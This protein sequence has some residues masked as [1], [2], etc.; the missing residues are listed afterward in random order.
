MELQGTSA[1][2]DSRGGRQVILYTIAL[3]AGKPGEYA[4][5]PV[6]LRYLPYGSQQPLVARVQGPTLVVEERR[7]MGLPPWAAGAAAAAL[8][9]VLAGLAVLARRRS[10]PR[11][12]PP[13]EPAAELQEA[14]D[15]ARERRL[16]GD[17]A[18]FVSMLLPAMRAHAPSSAT[19]AVLESWEEKVRYGGFVPTPM[20]LD[21]VERGA[22]QAI[23]KLR[24][25]GGEA[26]PSPGDGPGNARKGK[27]P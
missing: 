22:R 27:R 16:S 12:E 4:L 24:S 2:S 11:P 5:D 7:V 17:P 14:L 20:D 15:R 19:L 23:E 26:P 21:Q 9:V 1:S 10:S 3:R 13:P 6:E 18:G 8:L 25:S